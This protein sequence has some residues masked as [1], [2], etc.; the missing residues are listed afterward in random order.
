MNPLV[1]KEIERLNIVIGD[2]EYKVITLETER[3]EL[4]QD[5]R[6]LKEENARIELVLTKVVKEFNKL[7]SLTK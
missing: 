3:D 1:A 5:L 4:E 2:L 6:T 7:K